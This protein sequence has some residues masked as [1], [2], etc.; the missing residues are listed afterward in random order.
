MIKNSIFLKKFS[1]ALLSLMMVGIVSPKS[2]SSMK[3]DEDMSP[4]SV[5]RKLISIAKA[6]KISLED[7]NFV[8]KR[9]NN[10]DPKADYVLSLLY[11]DGR[12]LSK[13]LEDER[14]LL[15]A[16]LKHSGD[17]KELENFIKE[18]EQEESTN[19]NK[20]SE[21]TLDLSGP[22]DKEEMEPST[23]LNTSK[24]EDYPIINQA[25][26]R[27]FEEN[28]QESQIPVNSN[29]LPSNTNNEEQHPGIHINLPHNISLNLPFAENKEVGNTILSGLSW[30]GFKVDA[31]QENRTNENNK[32]GRHLEEM[33]KNNIIYGKDVRDA[34]LKKR[35]I[36]LKSQEEELRILNEKGYTYDYKRH[37]LEP[38]KK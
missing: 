14:E 33:R 9:S 2:A 23:T 17:T 31:P 34:R 18:L 28:K 16:A 11:K 27:I 24:L 22:K 3:G 4:R 12:G 5:T 1:T 19:P 10:K 37:I 8:E 6:K 32:W 25:P 21:F 35:G 30:L 26:S 13:S 15:E 36:T 7:L 20:K 29:P 38:L